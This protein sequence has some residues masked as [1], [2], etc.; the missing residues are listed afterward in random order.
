MTTIPQASLFAAQVEVQP[1]PH[2]WAGFVGRMFIALRLLTLRQRPQQCHV[3]G[4]L[5]PNYQDQ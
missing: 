4:Q 1:L 5:S 3:I 2:L